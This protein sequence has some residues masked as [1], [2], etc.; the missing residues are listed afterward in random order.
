VSKGDR[1]AADEQMLRAFLDAFNRHDLDDI[2]S[3]FTE[4]CKFDMPRGPKPFGTRYRGKAGVREGLASRFSGIPDVHYGDDRH[5]VSRSGD[6]GVSEWLLTGT[7]TNG[8]RI[9]VRGCDLFEFH[10][11]G[12]IKV[13]D[14]YWKIVQPKS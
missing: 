3:Y 11:D 12:K 2:M 5:F 13:K 10:E 6:R 9:E 8:E 4:D 14:S 1:K 7:A